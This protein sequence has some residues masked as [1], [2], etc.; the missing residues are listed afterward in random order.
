M[1]K[2][3]VELSPFI[4]YHYLFFFYIYYLNEITIWSLLLH[5]IKID[6]VGMSQKT[7]NQA[8][9]ELEVEAPENQRH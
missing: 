4:I 7:N 9:D 6:S 8:A 2:L 5:H 3:S 1:R